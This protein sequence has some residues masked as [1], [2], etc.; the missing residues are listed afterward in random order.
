M[1]PIQDRILVRY[2][3]GL[4]TE[5]FAWGRC[6]CNTIAANWCT[7][8]VGPH[9]ALDLIGT[10]DS[11]LSAKRV[12]K[13]LGRWRDYLGDLGFSRIDNGFVQAGDFLIWEGRAYDY[14]HIATWG[15]VL[16]VHPRIGVR[17]SKLERVRPDHLVMGVRNG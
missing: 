17:L 5:P 12:S 7:F 6:D 15:K 11:R 10:Y 4:L 9:R 13:V 2:I 14:I 3:E 1:E 16:S 8:L